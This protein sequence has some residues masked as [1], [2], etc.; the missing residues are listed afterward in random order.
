M[1][2]ILADRRVLPGPAPAVPDEAKG[3]SAAADGEIAERRLR[4]RWFKRHTFRCRSG[5]RISDL[6]PPWQSLSEAIGID[7]RHEDGVMG[8]KDIC[9]ENQPRRTVL[10]KRPESGSAAAFRNAPRMPPKAA[11]KFSDADP[12]P[13][14]ARHEPAGADGGELQDPADRASLLKRRAA[15]RFQ[16]PDPARAAEAVRAQS[17][18]VARRSQRG[19]PE[20]SGQSVQA[21][22]RTRTLRHGSK[23]SVLR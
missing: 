6:E 12:E 14:R 13:G 2:R 5:K 20:H 1:I 10:W 15:N 3:V 18:A 4:P 21:A 16:P 17:D 7:P 8:E 22:R 19:I 9:S 11:Q 23:T